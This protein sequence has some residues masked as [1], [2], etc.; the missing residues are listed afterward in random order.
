[1]ASLSPYLDFNVTLNFRTGRIIIE[2]ASNYPTGVAAGVTGIIT[3]LLPD[4]ITD[5]G[6]WD[7][8]D[9]E[10]VTGALTDGSKELRTQSDGFPQQGTYVI[11]YV[12]DHPDYTPT[13]LTKTFILSY[14]GVTP[15]ITELFDLF[16]PQL[17]V[18]DTT[19]YTKG[20]FGTPTITRAWE[21]VVGNVTTLTGS[22]SILDLIYNSSYYD[23]EYEIELI[24]DLTYVHSTY[25]YLTVID[26]RTAELETTAN[27]P[28]SFAT[29]STYLKTIKERFD[30]L[31][32][33]AQTTAARQDYQYAAAL[34][35][36]IKNRICDLDTVGLGDQ[37]EDFMNVYYQRVATVYVNT[38]EVIN[39]YDFDAACCC[40][41]EESSSVPDD[42]EF[43]VGTTANAPT[44]GVNT[45]DLSIFEGYNVR[46]HRS[47]IKQSQ[48]QFNGEPYFS[49]PKA[50]TILTLNGDTWQDGELL[51]IEFVPNNNTSVSDDLE[52]VV[53]TTSGAPTAGTSTLVISSMAGERVRL[54]RSRIKQSKLQFSSE[55]YY[56]KPLASDTLTLVGDT[57][58]TGELLQIEFY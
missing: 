20:G 1:M 26:R 8:P 17:R 45:W 13:T 38:N 5:A 11:T 12:V 29:L 10:Y 49:K 35:Q 33:C 57:W 31:E 43:I 54:Y 46:L 3:T 48:T 27:A 21:A 42:L 51:Q 30:S 53:G 15:E 2:D 22:S 32:S 56:S 55:P 50:L 52:F 28:A 41:D 39:A 6:D 4:G 40:G 9:V 23:A 18:Q 47:R 25:T 58:Q 44:A 24:V 16:S 7:N 36:H 19:V 34:L 37:I 14:K